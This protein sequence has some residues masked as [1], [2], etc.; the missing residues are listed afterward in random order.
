MDRDRVLRHC[1][2]ALYPFL[3]GE[4][5]LE[6]GIAADEQ[7]WSRSIKNRIIGLL[8]RFGWE[9]ARVGARCHCDDRVGQL[10]H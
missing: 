9:V 10:L 5:R 2:D 4:E 6:V 8:P 1:E 7:Y 3:G